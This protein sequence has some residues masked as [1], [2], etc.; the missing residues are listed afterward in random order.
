MC[1]RPSPEG[2]IFPEF[3]ESR[4]VK[5]FGIKPEFQVYRA[6]DWGWNYF[7]CLWIQED[8]DGNVFVVKEY[9]GEQRALPQNIEQIKAIEKPFAKQIK[10]TYVDPAGKAHNDQTGKQNVTVMEDAGI[11]CQ[12]RTSN[13]WRNVVNGINLIRD[14]LATASGHT[15]LFISKDCPWLIQSMQGYAWKKSNEIYLDEPE[16]NTPWEHPIDSLRYFMV[17]KKAGGGVQL[18]R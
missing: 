14:Y 8:K 2:V 1:L 13:R 4:H 17:N 11:T 6:I 16:Q 5:S 12:W 3:D 18:Y 10:A 9:K 15:R 7:C